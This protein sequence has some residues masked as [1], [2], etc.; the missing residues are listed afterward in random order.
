MAYVSARALFD[1]FVSP[2]VILGLVDLIHVMAGKD[3]KFCDFS[4]LYELPS[5]VL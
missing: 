1:S 5:A 2:S 3:L 4:L